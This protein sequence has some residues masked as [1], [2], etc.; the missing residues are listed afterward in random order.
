MTAPATA[1]A[2]GTWIVSF[3]ASR[4]FGGRS[5][6]WNAEDF[7]DRVYAIRHFTPLQG[8]NA[9]PGGPESGIVFNPGPGAGAGTL[10]R[11]RP[12]DAATEATALVRELLDLLNI[13]IECLENDVAV[14]GSV[15][16]GGLHVGPARNGPFFGPALSRARTMA[17]SR[18]L[19]SRITVQD[20]IIGRLRADASLW[21]EGHHLRA[22]LDLFD[23]MAARDE[24]GLHYIDYL[25]AGFGD[26]DRDSARYADVLGRHKRLVEAGLS[27][28]SGAAAGPYGW[29]KN[30][31]NACI[32]RDISRSVWAHD[33][34]ERHRAMVRTLTPLRIA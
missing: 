25:A 12:L 20:G 6:T 22:E 10:A 7:W 15:V 31:H 30:Y 27:G 34:Q 23:R 9:A 3:L 26:V 28:M 5:R 19:Q 18:I 29:L 1:P 17:R 11:A 24:T 33:R 21:T 32:D 13:Q 16:T 14:R 4:P 2:H 8:G